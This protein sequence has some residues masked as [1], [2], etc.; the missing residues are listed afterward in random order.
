MEGLQL[1]GRGAYPSFE[2]GGRRP[3][4]DAPLLFEV[5]I[6]PVAC[7]SYFTFHSSYNLRTEPYDFNLDFIRDALKTFK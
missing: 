3:G 5:R 1:S 7:E 6:E 4:T 2:I